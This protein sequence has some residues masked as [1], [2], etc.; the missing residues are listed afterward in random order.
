MEQW[1][2]ILQL[3]THWN[4]T[5]TSESG[6]MWLLDGH[7]IKY[8]QYSVNLTKSR[9]P[10]ETQVHPRNQTDRYC[11]GHCSYDNIGGGLNTSPNRWAWH[12]VLWYG[13]GYIQNNNQTN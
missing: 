10:Q 1:D 6:W 11:Q 2:D 13:F 9:T 5:I 8:S 7:R 12:I 3:H 4:A